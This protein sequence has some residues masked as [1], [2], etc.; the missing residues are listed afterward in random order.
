MQAQHTAHIASKTVSRSTRPQGPMERTPV[1]EARIYEDVTAW[2]EEQDE[3]EVSL[4]LE[5]ISGRNLRSA[6]RMRD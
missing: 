1:R 4:L 2:L 5:H 6:R 3:A